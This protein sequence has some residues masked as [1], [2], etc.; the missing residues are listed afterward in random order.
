M[1]PHYEPDE[2]VELA[3]RPFGFEPIEMEASA[4]ADLFYNLFGTIPNYFVGVWDFLEEE[5]HPGLRMEDLLFA[6]LC[7]KIFGVRIG[8]GPSGTSRGADVVM[9]LCKGSHALFCYWEANLAVG[10]QG[11]NEDPNA[12]EAMDEDEDPH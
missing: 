7:Q 4:A 10:D 3:L 11:E 12:G 5:E 9:A 8:E 1:L 6:K 2:V